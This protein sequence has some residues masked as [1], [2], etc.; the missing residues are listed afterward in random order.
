MIIVFEFK[1]SFQDTRRISEAQWNF[2]RPTF[3]R[4]WQE[5]RKCLM[6]EG[7]VKQIM[8]KQHGFKASSVCATLVEA[9]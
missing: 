2:H 8:E 9:T 1:M 5:E 3:Y 4:L 6:G 7:G